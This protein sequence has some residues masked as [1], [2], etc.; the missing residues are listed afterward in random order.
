MPPVREVG[1][2]LTGLV[3]RGTQGFPSLAAV[4]SV[5]GS[6][7]H[8]DETIAHGPAAKSP[9]ATRAGRLPNGTGGICA[10][11]PRTASEGEAKGDVEGTLDP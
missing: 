3:E 2:W 8:P 6:N 10:I 4:S 1:A 11:P 5:L 7:A 9:C